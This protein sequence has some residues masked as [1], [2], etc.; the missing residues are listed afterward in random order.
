M[1]KIIDFS[2]NMD[3]P[4]SGFSGPAAMVHVIASVYEMEVEVLHDYAHAVE[5]FLP[6]IAKKIGVEISDLL[7]DADSLADL[8]ENIKMG[9]YPPLVYHAS[10]EG[11]E[12]TIMIG[13]VPEEDDYCFCTAAEKTENKIRWNYDFDKNRWDKDDSYTIS[14]KLEQILDSDSPEADILDEILCAYEGKINDQEYQSLKSKNLKIF[15][16][17]KKVK[18]FMDPYFDVDMGK[19]LFLEPKDE[20]R[21]GFMVGCD[22]SEY[23]L[24]QFLHP[25]DLAVNGDLSEEILESYPKVLFRE[26]GRTADEKKI[27]SCLWGLANRYT[28]DTIYTVPLSLD[29]YTESSSLKHIGRRSYCAWGRKDDFNAAEKKALESVRNYVKNFK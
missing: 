28:D 14:S 22:G 26:V 21:Y 18:R 23:V 8:D 1:A 25:M 16:L 20:N 19:K 15:N 27:K 6:Q 9:E 13:M 7:L 11:T 4:A 3:I 12:Y 17:Y 29:T 10:R 24:Y 2:Q 5:E